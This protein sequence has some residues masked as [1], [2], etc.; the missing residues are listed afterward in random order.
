MLS[1]PVV[2]LKEYESV[3]LKHV[4]LKRVRELSILEEQH[5]NRNKYSNTFIK[6]TQC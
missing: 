4:Q 6:S 3:E 1:S 5:L 2:K